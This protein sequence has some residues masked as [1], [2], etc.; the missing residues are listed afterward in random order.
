MLTKEQRFWDERIKEGKKLRVT[1]TSLTETLSRSN[2]IYD[3]D[4]IVSSKYSRSKSLN[5]KIVKVYK[6]LPIYPFPNIGTYFE[7]ANPFL[8]PENKRIE[9]SKNTITIIRIKNKQDD[10]KT[11][12]KVIKS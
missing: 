12:I 1:M 8:F 10:F 6:P 4:V 7:I 11:T 9:V 3:Y 5:V 2:V